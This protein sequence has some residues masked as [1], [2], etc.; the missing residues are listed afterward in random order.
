MN[1]QELFWSEKY[2][3]SYI[4]KNSNFDEKLALKGWNKILTFFHQKNYIP[5]SILECGSNIGRN[6][7]YLNKIYP[8]S[9]KSIIEISKKA[10]E[11]SCNNYDL[12][13]SSNTSILKSNIE[14]QFDLVFTMGVLIHIHPDDLLSNLK[15]IFDYSSEYIIIGEYFNRTQSMIRYQGE[16]N[17]LFKN[18]YGKILNDN[19]NVK[20]CD[21]GFLW[22]EEF[23]KAG[24]DD[25]TYWVFRK[26]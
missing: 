12:K 25:I 23:D 22:G 17:K 2:E 7:N 24:F 18:N 26:E 3:Q 14:S 15:K 21:Y 1:E 9:E 10:F 11:I 20:I 6:I 19:F 4:N 16:E 8:K 13:Y 5:Q